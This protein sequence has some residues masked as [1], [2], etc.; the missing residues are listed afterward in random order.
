MRIF[1]IVVWIMYK[2]P[3]KPLPLYCELDQG[4]ALQ[5]EDC[6]LMRPE[7]GSACIWLTLCYRGTLDS[8]LR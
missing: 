6:L 2:I 1:G 4:V 8:M 5:Y 7:R 3:E